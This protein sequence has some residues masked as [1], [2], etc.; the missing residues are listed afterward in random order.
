MK[1]VDYCDY[2]ICDFLEFGWPVGHTGMPFESSYCRN[3]KGATDFPDDI[4]NY[5]KKESS[6][7]AIVGPFKSNPFNEP[8]AVSPINSVPK[9]ESLER[10]VIVDL[11]FPED[12]SVNNGI[13]KDQYLGETIS[14]HYPTIDNL[15]D[16][17]KKKGKGCHLFKRDLKRAYRQI[18]LDPGDIHLLGYKWRGHIYFDRVLTMGLRSAAY[19]CMRTTSAIRFMCLKNDID[20]LNY[21]DDLAGCEL[22]EKSKFAFNFL[23]ELLKCCGIEESMEKATHP[24]TKMV[25]IGILFD[26]E[27]LTISIDENRLSEIIDLVTVWLDKCSC[28]KK[29]L[30]S[31]LG[32]LN[33]VSQCVRPGRLFVSRLLNWLREISDIDTVSIPED[34]KLDLLWWK[35]FLPMYN[36]ISMMLSDEWA[37]ADQLLAVDACLTGCGG[38]MNGRFF[39]T[40]FPK[41]ILD[42]NLHINLCELLTIMVALKLWGSYFSSKKILINCDNLVSVRVLNTG[43]TRNTFL[44]SC[45]REICFIAAVNNFDVKAKHIAGC[46][47]RIPDSLSRWDLNS[48]FRDNF[49]CLTK[50]L[51]IIEDDLNSSFFS[52]NHD[53]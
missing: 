42:Q 30:Q 15:I 1:L 35:T 39:H 10:R 34:F 33:Y 11:S 7:K 13:L 14:V 38:W 49:S 21:L 2:Q 47:N 12:K 32:K 36:G 41:F 4:K 28:S 25:F 5:L 27:N 51:D 20:I 50:D 17:I 46:E 31:L 52:F 43:A 40:S 18:Y 16:L 44:Q 23:G 3:H 45:L 19:I 53:W 8:I 48:K 24:S 26:T 6:Y 22:P 9:K 37:S 29:E